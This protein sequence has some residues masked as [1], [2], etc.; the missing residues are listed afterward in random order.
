M[1]VEFEVDGLPPKK[2]GANS[3]WGKSHELPRIHALRLAAI[4]AIDRGRP[5]RRNICL[6]LELHLPP[7][8]LATSGDLDNFITGV[9]DG[10]QAAAGVKWR[11]HRWEGEEWEGVQPGDVVAIENDSQVVSI[12]ARKISDASDPWYKVVVCGD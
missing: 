7:T 11:A 9:C 12:A 8:G 6:D 2:D 4:R 10:L 3:M 1:R 5:F